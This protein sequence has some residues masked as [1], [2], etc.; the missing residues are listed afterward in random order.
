MVMGSAW[1]FVGV[2]VDLRRLECVVT[3]RLQQS[4]MDDEVN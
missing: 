2:N 3:L 1:N 4:I